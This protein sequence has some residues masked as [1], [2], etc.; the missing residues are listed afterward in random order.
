MAEKKGLTRTQVALGWLLS[1]VTSPVVGA[2]KAAH[3]EEAAAAV[4]VSL[5]AAECAYLEQ[6]YVPHRLVGVMQFNHA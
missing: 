3:L 1:K 5:T 2:T 6:P 4:E